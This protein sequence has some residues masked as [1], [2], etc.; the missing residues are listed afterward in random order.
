MPNELAEGHPTL[1][2]SYLF[3]PAQINILTLQHL[4]QHFEARNIIPASP[5]L[6]AMRNQLKAFIVILREELL[7][8][9][10]LQPRT[11]VNGLDFPFPVKKEASGAV[12]GSHRTVENYAVSHPGLAAAAATM[13]SHKA[14]SYV[15][16]FEV[17][18]TFF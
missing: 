4:R 7:Q 17:S 2:P 16:T 14:H 3:T 13:S 6:P 8:E 12:F 15:T 5:L 9:Q 18:G 10:A 1:D 11:R